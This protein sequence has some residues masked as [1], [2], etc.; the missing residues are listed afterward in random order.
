MFEGALV[1]ALVRPQ[2]SVRSVLLANLVLG[3]NVMPEFLQGDCTAPALA[4]ALVPLLGDTP[5]RHRQLAAFAA[6]DALMGLGTAPSVKAAE[7]VL[8]V[9]AR[10][11]AARLPDAGNVVSTGS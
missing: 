5:A 8:S 9:I 1:R 11:R 10:A 7:T 2:I 4:D 3:A 6:L